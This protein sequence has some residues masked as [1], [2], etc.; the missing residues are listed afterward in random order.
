MILWLWLWYIC[1]FNLV[2]SIYK[3]GWDNLLV[4]NG[5]KSFQDKIKEE[6]TTRVLNALMNRRSDRF[7]PFKPV[8]FT[9][10]LL[11]MNLSK[12]PKE[13]G[14]KPKSNNKP[15]NNKPTNNSSKLAH[16]YAQ[17]S[18]INIWDILKLKENISKLL[19]KKIEE[20]HKIVYNSNTPKLRL[21]MTTKDPLYKQ[22]I[23]SM[24]SDNIK[25]FI[26]LSNN[27][28]ININ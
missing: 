23:V 5:S 7:S 24:G 16:T 1:I 6:F 28:V 9:N 20:I 18:S 25:I 17:A 8:K 27:H 19:D 15:I 4:E 11:P 3:G 10:I 26:L 14:V 13:G 2:K 21:N 12:L 22:I